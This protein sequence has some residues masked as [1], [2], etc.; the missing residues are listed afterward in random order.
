MRTT[1]AKKRVDGQSRLTTA[2]AVKF[3]VEGERQTG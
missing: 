2:L 1:D 3:N